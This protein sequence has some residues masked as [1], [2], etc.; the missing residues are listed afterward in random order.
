MSHINRPAGFKMSSRVLSDGKKFTTW[1]HSQKPLEIAVI[2]MIIKILT[3]R[4]GD[5][6]C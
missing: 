2:I 1:D 6:F 5:L 3:F 4:L